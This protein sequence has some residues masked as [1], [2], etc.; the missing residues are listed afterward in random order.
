VDTASV[1]RADVREPLAQALQLRHFRRHVE[2]LG[3]SERGGD[4]VGGAGLVARRI[5]VQ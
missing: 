1:S 5:A 3:L 2:V 4:Q